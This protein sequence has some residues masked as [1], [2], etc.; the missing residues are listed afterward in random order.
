M[1]AAGKVITDAMGGGSL[2]AEQLS[3]HGKLCGWCTAAAAASVASVPL[4]VPEARRAWRALRSP[5]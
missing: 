4:V 3:K 1:L 5:G 2:F